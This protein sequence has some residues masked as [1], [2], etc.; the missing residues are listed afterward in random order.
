MDYRF[1]DAATDPEPASDALATE[2][3]VRFAPTAWAYLPPANAPEPGPLPA[4]RNGYVTFGAFNNFT[5]VTDETLRNWA[6]L[7][8]S[9]PASRLLLK[10]DGLAEPA[11]G[12]PVRARLR[13]AGI[14][15]ERVELLSRTPDTLSHLAL[16]G[17]VDIA[18]DTFPYHGTTTTCEALWMGVPVVTRAGDSHASR[19]G[20][21]LLRAV[22]HSEWIATTPE[23]YIRIAVTLAG[24]L[25]RLAELRASLR[26][27]MSR[28]ALLD[29]AGQAARF[30]AALRQNWRNWCVTKNSSVVAVPPELAFS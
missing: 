2:K 16:Y 7:L 30:G 15:E 11:V 14:A 21:S 24:D 26:D 29:H 27:Q 19:V 10:A 17:R 28:S 20:V 3:L 5:K 6:Q 8:N 23:E 4:L 25:L 12:E 9:V 18:L 1:V 22:G 13:A